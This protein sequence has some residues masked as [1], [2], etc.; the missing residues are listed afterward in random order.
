ML[1]GHNGITLETNN[2]PKQSREK[3]TK[4]E[5]SQSLNSKHT[6]KLQ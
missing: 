2:K 3:P 1:S 5:V 6:T 4:L